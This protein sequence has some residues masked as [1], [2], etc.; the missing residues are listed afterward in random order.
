MGRMAEDVF[1]TACHTR[2]TEGLHAFETELVSRLLRHG[3]ECAGQ[4]SLGPVDLRGAGG[5]LGRTL[6]PL[7]L[8]QSPGVSLSPLPPAGEHLSSASL[9]V[10]IKPCHSAERKVAK[11]GLGGGTAGTVPAGDSRR[12]GGACRSAQAGHV[13]G[14]K[15]RHS[16]AFRGARPPDLSW[17]LAQ[18]P[19]RFL[20]SAS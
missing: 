16:P 5:L 7:S 14:R 9:H 20:P 2:G 1:S 10:G 11:E 19:T 13:P 12:Q 4:I 18:S 6:A 3:L 15:L 17:G 8:G